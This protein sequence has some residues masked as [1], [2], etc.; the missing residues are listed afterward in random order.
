MSDLSL[1]L[2]KSIFSKRV[3]TR[4]MALYGYQ[5]FL[6]FQEGGGRGGSS[7]QGSFIT[8][9]QVEI[10]EILKRC[11]GQGAEIRA[12]FYRVVEEV[13]RERAE[14]GPSVLDILVKH[15]K[16]FFKEET[17]VLHLPSCFIADGVSDIKI[18]EPIRDLVNCIFHCIQCG[19]SKRKFV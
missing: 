8:A 12:E 4:R 1:L 5:N 3:E 15:A 10:L 19:D 17:G 6:L 18:T 14:V 16:A 2:R 11:L 9:R 7:S 13:C